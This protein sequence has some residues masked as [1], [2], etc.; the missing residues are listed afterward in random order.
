MTVAEVREVMR[1]MWAAN[2]P[3]LAHIYSPDA[4]DLAPARLRG[5]AVRAPPRGA[6]FVKAYRMFFLGVLLVPPNRVRPPSR[7]GEVVYEHPFNTSL[8]KARLTTKGS[9]T[10]SSGTHGRCC[11]TLCSV[12]VVPRFCMASQAE[13]RSA[14][15]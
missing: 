14:P 6:G 15:P 2:A 11:M 5:Q 1:R 3:V 10:H 9:F 8:Q 7:L 13:S 12:L 4:P